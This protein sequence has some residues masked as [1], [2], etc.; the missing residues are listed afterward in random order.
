[1]HAFVHLHAL[2]RLMGWRKGWL[3]GCLALL[4]AMALHA[5][6]G[7]PIE[8]D[9]A[10]AEVA[11]WLSDNGLAAVL[12][13]QRLA[14][15][16]PK[17][18][19]S[20]RRLQLDLG[21]RSEGG[22]TPEAASE[23]F[24]RS[25]TAF[26]GA[27]QTDLAQ[28]LFYKLV[29]LAGVPRADAFVAIHVQDENFGIELDA[30]QGRPVMRGDTGRTRLIRRS[31]GV[32]EYGSP[33]TSAGRGGIALAAVG[34]ELPRRVQRF[35]QTYF[36]RSAA[37]ARRPAPRV[38]LKPL[39]PNYAGIEVQGLRQFVLPAQPYWERLHVSIELQADTGGGSRAVCYLDG[40]YA[41]GLGT[42]LPP[43]TDY[44]DDMDP[45]FRSELERFADRLLLALQQELAR[46]GP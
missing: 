23:R 34:T 26:R 12:D 33:G 20:R 17:N 4:S 24:D 14:W 32:P 35:L 43:L 15:T 46:G 7:E 16:S 38:E 28:A 37:D 21:F 3:V 31:V 22:E 18:D 9:A 1:M 13:V 25:F 19:S 36:E 39:E 5:Q 11:R 27:G 29:H 6:V 30:T 45:K 40:R 42:R 10:R 41:A 8:L 44:V 2:D